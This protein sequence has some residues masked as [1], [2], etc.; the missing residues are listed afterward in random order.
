MESGFG[1]P[2]KKTPLTAHSVDTKF[3][4]VSSFFR[5]KKTR[6]LYTVDWHN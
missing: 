6:L 2:Q 5:G 1:L 3:D 4:I